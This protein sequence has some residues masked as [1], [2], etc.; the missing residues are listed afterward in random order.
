MTSLAT[1]DV[2]RAITEWGLAQSEAMRRESR[3]SLSSELFD[4]RGRT[5]VGFECYFEAVPRLLARLG[6]RLAPEEIGRRMKRP[7]SRP[8]YLQLFILM[9]NYLSAREQRLLVD[10]RAPEDGDPAQLE[11]L[12]TLVGFFH[13]AACAYR[14]DGRAVPTAPGF[15][16][17]ILDEDWVATCAEL[18]E[19]PERLAEV[20]R[21]V[22][23]ISLYSFLLHGEQRDGNFD[24]GPYRLADGTE[25]L[26]HELNDLDNDFLPWAERERPLSCSNV[27]VAYAL[28]DVEMRFSIFGGVVTDPVDFSS[29]VRALAVFTVEDGV[30]RRLETAELEG[31]V[32]RAAELQAALYPRIVEWPRIER[33]RYGRWLYANHLVPFFRLAGAEEHVAEIAERFREVGQRAAEEFLGAAELPEIFHNH[34]Q[35]TESSMFSPLARVEQ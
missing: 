5:W 2:D 11:E 18:L 9:S 20:Q 7:G 17:R 19:P 33:S 1:A 27:C 25:L 16:Q 4:I 35:L 15:D 23:A 10:G 32:Q 29:R 30:A 3:G 31:L 26:L 34:T 13:G 22:A 14:N 28:E 21:A 12:R 6:E 24:H 8:Y